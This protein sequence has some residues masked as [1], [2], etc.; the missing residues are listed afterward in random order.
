MYL[1][2]LDQYYLRN[3][4]VNQSSI[5]YARNNQLL[6]VILNDSLDGT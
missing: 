3:L 5:L 1:H 4:D 6:Y 2:F